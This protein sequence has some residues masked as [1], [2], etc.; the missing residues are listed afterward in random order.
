MNPNDY[1][2][3][4]LPQDFFQKIEAGRINRQ[5]FPPFSDRAAW[6]A[7][8][9]QPS[10]RTVIREL[11]DEAE[12][13]RTVPP[14]V[15]LYSSY[16]EYG[17]NGNRI[18]FEAPYFDRRNHLGTLVLAL[19]LTGNRDRWLMPV[20][21]YL[22]AILEEQS[23]CMP[24]H[25]RWNGAFP[26]PLRCQSDLFASETAAQLGATVNL[27]GDVF[28]EVCP[29]L[30]ERIRTETLERTVRKALDPAISWMQFWFHSEVP[31]NWT[32][33]CSYNL[34]FAAVCLENNPQKLS[35]CFHAYLQPVSRF[36]YHYADDGYCAEGPSYYSKAGG[37]LF[38]LT[39]V[40]DKMLP[41]CM[42]KYYAEPKT[43][44][45]FEFITKLRIGNDQVSF[46]DSQPHQ[47]PLLSLVLPCGERFRS[48]ALLDYGRNQVLHIQSWCGDELCETLALLFD[49]PAEFSTEPVKLPAVS[50]F[51]DRL[52]VLRSAHFSATL[53]GGY[54]KEPHNH[55]DLGHFTLYNGT[56]PVIVD[57]GSGLYTK[58][59]F[60]PL[61]YTIWYTRGS[62]HNAPV[63][64]GLEQ[65][66]GTERAVLG[67]P[68][69]TPEGT[70]LVCDLSKVYPAEAG[71]RSLKRVMLYSEN[72]VVV[73]DSF[74]L[75][76]PRTTYINLITAE[77]PVVEG[78]AI[79]LGDTLLTLDG[80][81]FSGTEALPD[82][83]HDRSRKRAWSSPLT[84]IVLK[85]ANTHY[86]MIF[87]T[88]EAK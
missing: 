78:S 2:I 52:S 80:I 67:D 53:K 76:A 9:T 15:L 10:K 64:D 61:R 72:K 23:W 74:E 54:N 70:R 36:A 68:E 47:L 8:K 33:W 20:L 21:D 87:T 85:T 56:K 58:L 45:I 3:S 19:C 30:V 27:L 81:E 31:G 29:G 79:R 4:F 40:M 1:L 57:A 24:A 84:R 48:P 5:L 77:T 35:D 38:K 41:G 34:L 63:F 51:H 43:R 69:V 13:L 86:K 16:C 65:P 14:P 12:Q 83:L 55:N 18:N 42:D 60:S 50:T 7:L 39:D 73:E 66:E 25:A 17:I 59:N 37:M 82:L 62:G 44:A 46:G 32:P 88:G 71:V 26:N 49:A 28:E 75:A 11:L 22:F 6:E